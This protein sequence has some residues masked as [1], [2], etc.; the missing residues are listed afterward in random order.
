LEK[1]LTIA[2]E[3]AEIGCEEV[4]L[5]GGEVT[6]FPGW[7]L[8]ADRL[9]DCGVSANIITNG[10]NISEE[11]FERIIKSKMSTVCVSVDGMEDNHNAIRGKADCFSQLKAFINKLHGTDK[12]ITAVTTL[13]RQ[14]IDDLGEL[15]DFLSKNNV[16]I[17]QWQICSPFGN[18]KDNTEI[19]PI[20]SDIPKIV[21]EYNQLPKGPMMVQLADNIGY[22]VSCPGGNNLLEFG[23]CA[24]GLSVI[25]ID[26]T[27]DVRGCESLKDDR[28]I[29]GNLKTQTLRDIWQDAE[30]FSYNRGFSPS[31]LTGGCAECVHGGF[32]AGGCRSH[33]YFA[34]QKLYESTVCAKDANVSL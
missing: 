5:I 7:D 2:D 32:C 28:F 4:C 11:I 24:A 21:Q 20:K 29:E 22:Y 30:R 1:C 25:G 16:L 15:F 31:F 23:G 14:N 33:N 10:Y 9:V 8:I 12:Y 34:H 3:L 18:A 17:W 19:T 6:M 27:G 26:S 13:T